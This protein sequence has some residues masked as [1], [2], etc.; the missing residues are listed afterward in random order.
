[1]LSV[2]CAIACLSVTSSHGCVIQKQLK[3]ATSLYFQRGK[4]HPKILRGSSRDGK[5]G[6]GKISHFLALSVNISK[7]L[8]DGQSYY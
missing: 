1:M 4:F 6:V 3:V 5:G 2:L 8:A 7:T